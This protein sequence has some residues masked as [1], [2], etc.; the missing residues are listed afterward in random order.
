METPTLAKL[1]KTLAGLSLG[2]FLG[3]T[4]PTVH[5]ERGAH[6]QDRDRARLLHGPDW[7]H[8]RSDDSVWVVNRDKGTVTV[9]DAD[10]G[11]DT[12]RRARPGRPRMTC[13]ARTTSSCRNG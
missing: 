9:F 8:D 5:A 1:L 6:D 12:D 2:V 3:S 13:Q 7:N 4:L 10:T 11:E